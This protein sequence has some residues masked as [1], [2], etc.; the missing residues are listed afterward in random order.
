MQH[1][2]YMAEKFLIFKS[3]VVPAAAIIG[4]VV[5]ISGCGKYL[6]EEE[7]R[8]ENIEKDKAGH[9]LGNAVFTESLDCKQVVNCALQHNLQAKLV[10]REQEIKKE[11][12]NQAWFKM[13]PSLK[14]DI[15]KNHRN[16]SAASSSVGL[17]SGQEA[18]TTSYSSD[19]RSRTATLNAVWNV[20]DFGI[21]FFAARQADNRILLGEQDLRR[22]RQT[23]ALDTYKAYWTAVISD[24]AARES[25]ELL[26]L[27]DSRL[28]NLEGS[29]EDKTLSRIIGLRTKK[30]LLTIKKRLKG[31]QKESEAARN[32]LARLMGVG[33]ASG[34]SL[35]PVDFP[36]VKK[37]YKYNVKKLQYEAL[38]NRP[39]LF[40][41]DIEEKITADDMRIA[42]LK[43]LPSPSVMLK[44]N[45]DD[46]PHLYANYWK[47]AG[48]S[49][50]W[51]L[52]EI[53][54]HIKEHE[55]GKLR[56]EL[57]NKRRLSLAV[58]ILTQVNISLIDYED[59]I[60]RT[61]A[62]SEV[63]QIQDELLDV[64]ETMF[65]EGTVSEAAL[66]STKIDSFFA[67]LSYMQ[68]YASLLTNIGIIK[69][70][71]GRDPVIS[72]EPLPIV[73]VTVPE[74]M[75]GRDKNELAEL[76][77]RELEKLRQFVDE[78]KT[79]G[80]YGKS[81]TDMP[82]LQHRSGG[83]ISEQEKKVAELESLDKVAELLASKSNTISRAAKNRLE[84]EGE[85]G[86]AAAIGMLESKERNARVM[87][88]LVISKSGNKQQKSKLVSAL[89]DSYSQSRY[90]ASLALR[91]EFDQDFGYNFQGTENERRT[92][93]VRWQD[94]LQKQSF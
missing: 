19:K 67:K 5:L 14:L 20:L 45:W 49:V 10:E 69:N 17:E 79:Y 25:E 7:F 2:K 77:A 11:L 78:Q 75:E 34:F 6:T 86:A 33:N 94:Y 54:L 84:K 13:L 3:K 93:Q 18:L 12:A 90:Y 64:T 85:A 57:I 76:K 23:L 47:D 40:K 80:L 42:A 87:A 50:A 66:L 29:L 38:R 39:E 41:E 15:D 4:I 73:M 48:V 91:E 59:A 35:I 46:N 61:L 68:S 21:S 72:R 71:I 81:Y 27:L 31:Y 28:N 70:T 55:T 65:S 44:H 51:N 43:T 56:Y 63:S 8:K 88:I 9:P 62:T 82:E 60:N 74:Q 30:D 52:L 89:A 1:I 92:A 26:E 32:E 83:T 53:P 16:Q 58:A 37:F 24:W 36:Y 22:T